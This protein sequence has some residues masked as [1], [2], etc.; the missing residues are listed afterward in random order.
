LIA[1]E[2]RVGKGDQEGDQEARDESET[3]TIGVML[4]RC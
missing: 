2:E 3:D 1:V 4:S